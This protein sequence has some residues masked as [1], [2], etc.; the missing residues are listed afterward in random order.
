MLA[1][2]CSRPP[3]CRT[4]PRRWRAVAPA[5]NLPP[6]LWCRLCGARARPVLIRNAALLRCWKPVVEAGLPLRPRLGV[7]APKWPFEIGR[8]GH[9]ANSNL[10]NGNVRPETLG[11]TRRERSPERAKPTA[12]T[13]SP[14]TGYGNVGLF[15]TL[16]SHVGLRGLP[17]GGRSPDKPVCREPDFPAIREKNRE[18]LE[19][20]PVLTK[21]SSERLR[22]LRVLRANSLEVCPETSC[23]IA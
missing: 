14:R 11:D 15:L 10:G 1:A 18:L 4:S 3:L 6:A 2:S 16:G 21:C 13:G 17:G 5:R 7:R 9:L 22:V 23:G 8:G 19:F 12:E 20:G